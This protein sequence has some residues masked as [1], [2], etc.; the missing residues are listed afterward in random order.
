MFQI[1]ADFLGKTRE[2]IEIISNDVF[3]VNSEFARSKNLLRDIIVQLTSSRIRDQILMKHSQN[4]LEIQGGKILFMK[5]LPK[6]I[7][8]SRRSY[9]KIVDKLKGDNVRYR[10]EL[11]EGLSFV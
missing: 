3:R 9:K 7:I 10:W 5:E 1:L 4:P 8:Q 6:E 11:P 2:E